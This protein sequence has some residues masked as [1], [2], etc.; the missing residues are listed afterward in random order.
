M[1]VEHASV[2]NPNYNA[3]GSHLSPR[4]VIMHNEE[5]VESDNSMMVEDCEVEKEVV[6]PTSSNIIILDYDDTILASTWLSANN[7]SL[8]S[9][10]EEV[11]HHAEE[12][13]VLEACAA[14]L[15]SK[16][17]ELGDV[18]L[19]T[20]AENGWI[21]LT[22]DKFLPALKPLLPHIQVVSAR[23]SYEHHS[24]NPREWKVLAFHSLIEKDTAECKNIVS[25][26]DS[27]HERQA[28]HI[29]T[30]SLTNS[31]AKSIKFVERP[32]MDILRRQIEL[33][34]SCIEYII[35]YEGDLDLMLSQ[36]LN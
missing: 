29:V 17:L 14:K 15:L 7:L 6:A 21:Q 4:S 35:N 20:N 23:S 19:V 33:I 11:A 9:T 12:L 31:F 28:L 3:K 18:H 5:E 25:L 16:A 8:N 13:R 36:I 1:E 2:M 24:S 10:F 34:S 30:S 26:G 32:T 22:V 27:H